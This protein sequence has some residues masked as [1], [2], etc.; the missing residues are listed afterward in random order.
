MQIAL[1]LEKNWILS[2]NWK[3]IPVQIDVIGINS[4]SE[5]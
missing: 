2:E 5:L 4:S 1:K 3:L